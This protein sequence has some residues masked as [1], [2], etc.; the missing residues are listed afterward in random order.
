MARPKGIY[1][2]GVNQPR[3]SKG[4]FRTVLARLKQDL[5]ASGLQSVIEKV[6]EAENL[7]NAGNYS[8]AVAAAADL[9]SVIDRIDTGGLNPDAL[10]NIRSSTAALGSL[11][12]NLPLP[13]GDQ[14]DKLRY[15][16]LPP[17]LKN[18][19]DDMMSRVEEKIGKKEAD[20]ATENLR[21]FKSGSSVM[22]QSDVSSEMNVMLRLLT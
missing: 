2:S 3:D 13:F 4:K 5:G 8:A 18:M 11:I 21:K 7:D 19:I 17:V 15:S 6:E 22:S 20:T 10:E 14:T 1:V 16:D 12:A 9:L